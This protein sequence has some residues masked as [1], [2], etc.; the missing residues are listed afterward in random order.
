M[1]LAGLRPPP[2]PAEGGRP[3]GPATAATGSREGLGRFGGAK[4]DYDEKFPQGPGQPA[5]DEVSAFGRPDPDAR[6][7]TRTDVILTPH[8]YRPIQAPREV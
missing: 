6:Q 5:P 7:R 2:L 4:A 8:G 1:S 3:T